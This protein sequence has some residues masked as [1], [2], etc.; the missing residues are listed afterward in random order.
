MPYATPFTADDIEDPR[1]WIR[2]ARYEFTEAVLYALQDKAG[3]EA[4]LL[5]LTQSKSE[6]EIEFTIDQ[7]LPELADSMVMIQAVLFLLDKQ[8]LLEALEY[9]KPEPET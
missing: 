1:E 7:L 5:D 2:Q 9:R 3:G 6:G 4:E 8:A